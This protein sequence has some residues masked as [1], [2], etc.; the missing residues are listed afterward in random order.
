V[1]HNSASVI[2][3]TQSQTIAKQ[4]EQEDYLA[5]PRFIRLSALLLALSL[6]TAHAVP[7]YVDTDWEAGGG[8]SGN[9]LMARLA[10]AANWSG[11]KNPCIPATAAKPAEDAKATATERAAASKNCPAVE[12]D[13]KADPKRGAPKPMLRLP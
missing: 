4:R 5:M 8:S 7:V 9:G 10:R 2:T 12:T 6:G 3:E 1:R 11:D 13:A